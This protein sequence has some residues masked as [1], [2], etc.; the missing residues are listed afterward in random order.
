MVPPFVP[1]RPARA[2]F[3]LIELLVVVAIIAI[4]AAM[5]LPALNRAR[6]KA[7]LSLDMNNQRQLAIGLSSYTS[8]FDGWF[9]DNAYNRPYNWT[10]ADASRLVALT[11]VPAEM[12]ACPHLVG[13]R[14]RGT[15]TTTFTPWADM[16]GNAWWFTYSL[17]A[18]F[19]PTGP[20]YLSNANTWPATGNRLLRR[21]GHAS[22]PADAAAIVELNGRFP[23][24]IEWPNPY[25]YNH[26][27]Y[28]DRWGELAYN[29]G[30]WLGENETFVDGHSEWVP[31]HQIVP[32]IT[33]ADGYVLS[34]K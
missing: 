24:Y 5:L 11:G 28:N 15:L 20:I 10:Y 14:L 1:P 8:D 30:P 21:E 4:L 33:Q 17:L 12:I 18:G 19:A 6:D 22:S 9:F 2:H 3:T 25:W 29:E 26:K 27:P 16:G 23:S 34:A 7:R 31:S 32:R 13:R